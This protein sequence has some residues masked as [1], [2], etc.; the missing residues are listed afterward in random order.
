II[1]P[2]LIG[3]RM[4]G[5]MRIFLVYP[6]FAVYAQVMPTVPL[7]ETLHRG[8]GMLSQS[9]RKTFSWNVLISIFFW[10]W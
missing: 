7:F 2:R 3:D 5:I 6:T 8:E 4:A 1:T 9:K 10:Q